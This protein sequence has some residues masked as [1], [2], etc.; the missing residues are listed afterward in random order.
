MDEAPPALKHD[1]ELI[2]GAL[3]VHD[4][5]T[6]CSSASSST[7]NGSPDAAAIVIVRAS[8]KERE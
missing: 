2:P 8:L 7:L 5:I 1:G 4:H 3:R 6:R